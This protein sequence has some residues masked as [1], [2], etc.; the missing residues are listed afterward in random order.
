MT[1]RWLGGFG[2]VGYRSFHGPLQLVGP[3]GKVNLLAGQNNAGKSNVL[4]FAAK[5][6]GANEAPTGLDVPQGRDVVGGFEFAVAD[7]IPDDEIKQH[8]DGPGQ[9]RDPHQLEQV[10][11][12]ILEHDAVRLTNDD[13]V[14]FR[15]AAEPT[16]SGSSGVIGLSSEQLGQIAEAFARTPETLAMRRRL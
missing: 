10:V 1:S 7:R 4:R 5:Y 16:S 8:L 14:W 6:L 9:R 12:R 13:L 15:Y 11:R 3:L 2:L